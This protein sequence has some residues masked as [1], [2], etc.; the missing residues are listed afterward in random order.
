L[1]FT[2]AFTES[3]F[4][5]EANLKEKID[6]VDKKMGETK[7]EKTKITGEISRIKKR[8]VKKQEDI[9]KEQNKVL[10]L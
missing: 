1:L 3:L 5:E 8:K 9:V 6:G 2:G 10:C 4:R 7:L